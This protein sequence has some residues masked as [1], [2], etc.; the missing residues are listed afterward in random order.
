MEQRPGQSARDHYWRQKSARPLQKPNLDR[1]KHVNH[2]KVSKRR[3]G[4]SNSSPNAL[5]AMIMSRKMLAGTHTRWTF[6]CITDNNF[7]INKEVPSAEPYRIWRTA[8]DKKTTKLNV[9]CPVLLQCSEIK[10]MGSNKKFDIN[11]AQKERFCNTAFPSA[12]FLHSRTAA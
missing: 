3:T 10:L 7:A 12:A 11:K 6:V 9:Y 4:N 1:Q 5:T 8:R 2:V